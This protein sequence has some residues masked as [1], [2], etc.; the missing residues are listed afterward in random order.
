MSELE[1]SMTTPQRRS[2]AVPEQASIRAVFHGNDNA[3][4]AGLGPR[5]LEGREK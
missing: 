3:I 1:F 2:Q 5:K 4:N